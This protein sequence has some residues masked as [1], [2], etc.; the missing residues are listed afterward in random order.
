MPEHRVFPIAGIIREE[1]DPRD[2]YERGQTR[3]PGETI[4][5]GSEVRDSFEVNDSSDV[6]SSESSELDSSEDDYFFPGLLPQNAPKQK[7]LPDLVEKRFWLMIF[8]MSRK[9]AF[10]PDLQSSLLFLTILKPF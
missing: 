9:I 3:P 1:P 6:D 10:S 2:T 7:I 4:R 8:T 5:L